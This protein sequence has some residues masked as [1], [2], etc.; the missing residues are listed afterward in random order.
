VFTPPLQQRGWDI[1]CPRPKKDLRCPPLL[2]QHLDL[3]RLGPEQL[4]PALSGLR[5]ILC[6]EGYADPLAAP[7]YA[8]H[9]EVRPPRAVIVPHMMVRAVAL[10]GVE[11]ENLSHASLFIGP[12]DSQPE[13]FE[14]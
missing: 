5:T 7:S 11:R 6:A 1:R 14:S 12:S 2:D 8:G 10:V 9:A 4:I 13:D 3:V